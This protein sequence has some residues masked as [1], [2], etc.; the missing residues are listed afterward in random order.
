[1]NVDVTSSVGQHAGSRFLI[2]Q[3]AR[4][5]LRLSDMDVLFA[6]CGDAVEVNEF[7]SVGCRMTAID[8]QLHEGLRS[9][10]EVRFVECPIEQMPFG[11]GSFDVILCS[12][13]LEHVARPRAALAEIHR[14]LR[15]GGCLYVGVP[16]RRRLVGYVGSRETS[17]ATKVRWNVAATGKSIS[18]S[19][20]HERIRRGSNRGATVLV[21]SIAK[22][23]K[24]R[25]V[26][27]ANSAE[28]M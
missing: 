17:L 18:A 22:A 8:I 7:R 21:I 24:P 28:T 3:L 26:T 20:T 23:P 11:D 4:R 27:E 19:A 16:N 9:D 12:H 6:G 15:P 14:V 5:E 10:S 13:V 2:E 25:S 1:V